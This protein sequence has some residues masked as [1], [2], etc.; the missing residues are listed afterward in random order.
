MPPETYLLTHDIGTTGNKTCLYH[1]P[2]TGKSLEMVASSLVEYPLYMVAGGGVEQKAD[3]WWQA[4]CQATRTVTRQ[5]GISGSQIQG[6]AFCAQMQGFVPVDRQGRALR[7]PLSYMDSRSGEQIRRGLYHGFPRINGWNAVKT[8]RALQITGGLAATVKDPLWKYHWVRDN[9]PHIFDQMYK[10]LDVKDYL[11]LRSTGEFCMGYDSAHA[12]FVYDTRPTKLGWHTGLCQLFDIGPQH[13]PVV[14]PATAVAGKLTQQAAEEMGLVAGIPVFGGGGDLSMITVGAGCFNIYDTHIYIGTSGWVVSTVDRR[15]TDIDGMVASILGAIPGAYNYIAEQET[16]G[17]CLQWVRDHLALDE[18]GVY[19]E[20]QRV[21]ELQEIHRSLY[22]LLNQ[23]VEQS[24]PGAGGVI[25]TPWLHG[26]RSPFEDPLARGMFFNIGLE[27]NKRDL[28]RSVL[29]G[30]AY[31][32][33][34]MLET[35]EKKIPHRDSLRFVGGGAQS[36]I[37]GQILADITGRQIE[38]TANAQNA[39]TIGAAIV[40]AVGLGLFSSFQDASPL[41]QVSRTFT[42]R[43]EYQDLYARQFSVYKQLYANNRKL[44]HA[45]N[46]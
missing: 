8:L 18:I 19:L 20:Q 43:P 2:S 32:K 31:H 13:L 1:L 30:V 26:N 41:I 34:W 4:V 35:I 22:S 17:R 23:T 6:M 29:E 9:E 36:G 46:Q 33:R 39:G 14:I 3:D 16:A 38:V 15:M 21:S 5:T 45:L 7:N 27:T 37:W 25:F 11:V 10:W 42:P 44:F 12:T 40:C 24:Q 28:I